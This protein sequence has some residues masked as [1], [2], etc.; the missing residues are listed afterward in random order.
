MMHPRPLRHRAG[1]DQRA[2]RDELEGRLPFGE[3]AD[4]D[5]DLQAGEEFAQARDDDLAQQDDERR[6]QVPVGD[7]RHRG[8]LAG[9]RATSSRITA[10]TMI[11][12]A[13][14]SRNWPSRD[15]VPCARAR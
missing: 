2:Q 5:R 13:I 7:D 10:A 8:P 4:R 3:L 15:T 6:D 12:S 1:E 9:G 14:G 11:L